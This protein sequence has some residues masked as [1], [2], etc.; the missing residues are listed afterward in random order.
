VLG[1]AKED[2]DAVGGF[3]E[4]DFFGFIASHEGDDYDLSF[5]TLKIICC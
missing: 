3:E 2:V 1:T 5:L 4:A